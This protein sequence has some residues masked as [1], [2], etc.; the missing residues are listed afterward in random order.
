MLR[1][2]PFPVTAA[3]CLHNGSA[4]IG[5]ALASVL[6]QTA[7]DFELLVVDDG[8]TDGAAAFLEA[9]IRDPRLIVVRTPHRGL[10]AARALVVSR[11]KGEWIAFL[12]Q[13]D[14]WE[15]RKLERFLG[16]AESHPDAALI[17]SDSRLM[18]EAGAPLGLWTDRFDRGGLDLGPGAAE[19]EL[20]RRGCFID[21]SAAMVKREVALQEGNFD[22]R[23]HYVEDFDLWLRIARRRRL[24]RIPESLSRRRIHAGQF[25]QAQPETALAEQMALLR[26][27]TTDLALPPSLRIA[28]GDYLLGQHYECGRRLFYQGRYRAVVR[29]VC[30]AFRFP[31]RIIDAAH[32]L[33]LRRGAPRLV[34]DAVV[35]TLSVFVRIGNRLARIAESLRGGST[36]PARIHID[37]SPLG[38]ERTGY[39]TFVTELIRSLIVEGPGA[40]IV[41]VSIAAGGRRA[42]RESLG[43]PAGRLRLRRA[44]FGRLHWAAFYAAAARPVVQVLSGLGASGLILAGLITPLRPLAYLGAGWAFLISLFWA[45]QTL[46]AEPGAAAAG[47]GRRCFRGPRSSSTTDCGR[48]AED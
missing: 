26:P 9:W 34:R 22:P 8:S 15:P 7:S 43:P 4:F 33:L 41:R 45:D 23:F 44:L 27:R 37:G 29:V 48:R 24:A 31:D 35:S 39:F 38:D 28:V 32:C 5:E 42:L 10:G 25:T 17:F 40:P 19:R 21:V 36:G 16:A 30:G 2:D 12:D 46:S 3:I 13:D 14:V 1:P 20:L 6:A 47:P 18:D 11:A